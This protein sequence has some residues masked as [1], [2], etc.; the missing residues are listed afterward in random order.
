MAPTGNPPG[1][2]RGTKAQRA[3]KAEQLLEQTY[4]RSFTPRCRQSPA[5]AAGAHKR[6]AVSP[7]Y[8]T[9]SVKRTQP[10]ATGVS[11]EEYALNPVYRAASR[12]A[13]GVA[14]HLSS[15]LT[16]GPTLSRSRLSV[17]RSLPGAAT[18][19]IPPIWPGVSATVS[20]ACSFTAFR[21]LVHRDCVYPRGHG[22]LM[23]CGYP[24]GGTGG[25]G[26]NG[27]R[28]G[29]TEGGQSPQKRRALKEPE[30]WQLMDP[31]GRA[32]TQGGRRVHSRS[33]M[34]VHGGRER[35]DCSSSP[36]TA[37]VVLSGSCTE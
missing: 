1:R 21:P 17:A 7:P 12:S 32:W 5:G 20:G 2:L 37:G 30:V 23:G 36:S 27:A 11:R 31:T 18:G 28:K 14:R 3:Q 26:V 10:N 34:S 13:S 24:S 35:S 9:R 8:Q 29:E 25:R 4:R 22:G 15:R 6:R 19:R 33:H 16:S